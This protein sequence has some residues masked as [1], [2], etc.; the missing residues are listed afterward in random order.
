M[1]ML[2]NDNLRKQLKLM[3]LNLKWRTIIFNKGSAKSVVDKVVD[4]LAKITELADNWWW[5]AIRCSVCPSWCVAFQILQVAGQANTFIFPSKLANIGY[6]IAQR[7]G[8]FKQSA[9]SYKGLD[10]PVSRFITWCQR[11]KDVYKVLSLQ[12]HKR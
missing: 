7:L 10:K 8:G 1:L 5:I 12:L 3:T 2:E 4:K 6:K 9:Q 11:K